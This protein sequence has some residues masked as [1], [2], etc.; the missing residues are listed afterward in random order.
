MTL[1]SPPGVIVPPT[2][3]SV[4]A[5]AGAFARASGF[6][7]PDSALLHL[8]HVHGTPA[9]GIF[10]PT[11]PA[12]YGPWMTGEAVAAGLDCSPCNG[13]GCPGSP[14]M[15]A[16]EAGAVLAA[17]ERVAARAGRGADSPLAFRGTMK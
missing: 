8:A 5:M 2:A 3:P 12:L 13:R 11:D 10:G 4:L 14:C 6:A 17:I 1:A 7:G 15:E 9:V 16:V